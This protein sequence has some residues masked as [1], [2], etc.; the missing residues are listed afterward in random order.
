VVGQEFGGLGCI[1][2]GVAH[3]HGGQPGVAYQGLDVAHLA[4][5]VGRVP[6]GFHID[7]AL[8]LHRGGGRVTQVVVMEVVA[9]QSG[10]VAV[11]EG[12]GWLIA[13]PG[14]AVAAQVP[15][16]VVGVDDAAWHGDGR[17]G[18]RGAA[19]QGSLQG[20]VSADADRGN[21]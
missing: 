5:R 9:P 15:E 7:R 2:P 1:Q 12:N 10:V 16:V 11:A 6:L 17:L 4:A 19:R 21:P 3:G 14:V 13:Q 18:R 20:A 8:H